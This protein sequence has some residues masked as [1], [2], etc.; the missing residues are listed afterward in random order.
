M[1]TLTDRYI[2]EVVRGVPESQRA[3]V[4]QE[5]R[6]SIADAVARATG[7]PGGSDDAG[8]SAEATALTELG[9][10]AKLA[11][12]L[13]DGPPDRSASARPWAP[14]WACWS[15]SRP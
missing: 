8:D 4:E 5:L 3:D 9:D 14:S 1:S 13:T 15:A 12:S 6:A 11:A 2:A 7:A 10:P